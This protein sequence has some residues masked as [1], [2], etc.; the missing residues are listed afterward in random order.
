MDAGTFAVGNRTQGASPSGMQ[1][2]LLAR[3]ELIVVSA[4]SEPGACAADAGFCQI[5]GAYP[6]AI[7]WATT[8]P[9]DAGAS[10]YGLPFA[11][12]CAFPDTMG[13][14]K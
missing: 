2:A 9:P 12:R 1:D 7:D 13:G 11:F 6:G 10:D 3:A 14:S 5:H 8:V 4:T